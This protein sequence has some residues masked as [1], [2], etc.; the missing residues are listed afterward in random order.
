MNETTGHDRD[1]FMSIGD[2]QTCLKMRLSGTSTKRRLRVLKWN[3][4]KR[5]GRDFAFLL[6]DKLD[7]DVLG[8]IRRRNPLNL[9]DDRFAWLNESVSK[10]KGGIVEDI[11]ALF[12]NRLADFYHG[13]VAFHGCRPVSLDS[14]KTNGLKPSD[15]EAIKR[16]AKEMFGDTAALQEAILD[17]GSNYENHNRGVVWMCL[18]RESFLRRHHEGYLLRGSEYLSAISNRLGQADK[19]RA[20]GV[21]TIIECF[22]CHSQV[23]QQCWPSLSRALIEDWFE[24]FLRPDR[25]RPVSTF[26]IDVKT[27]IPPA[28]ILRFHQFKEV[29]QTHSWQDFRTKERNVAETVCFRPRRE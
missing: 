13:I 2:S 28:Q 11:P 27:T 16:Q 26:C 9:R 19:L 24:R 3:Q 14:Y 17:I 18:T 6:G 1:N 5:W 10:V 20:N 7:N 12:A 15:T 25:R 23:P 21:P 4:R 8:E 22:V 29:R